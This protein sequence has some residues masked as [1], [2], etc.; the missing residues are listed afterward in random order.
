M[1]TVN[2]GET[3]STPLIKIEGLHYQ[4]LGGNVPPEQDAEVVGVCLK[5]RWQPDLLFLK[6]DDFTRLLVRD[7]NP[8]EDAT[9]ADLKRAAY[10]FI[11]DTL[12]A[13]AKADI[14]G[15]DDHHRTLYG[16]MQAQDQRASCNELAPKSARWSQASEGVKQLLYDKISSASINGRLLV[17]VGK[18][19]LP[20]MRREITLR[21]DAK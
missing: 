12:G 5:G 1:A 9:L 18:A 16:W 15:L 2:E 21:S 10:H 14:D 13:L 20:I 11:Y 3:R 17:L 7:S 19:L 4:S 8:A 6:P